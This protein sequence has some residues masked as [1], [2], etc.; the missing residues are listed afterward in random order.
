MR[1]TQIK[2][3][4]RFEDTRTGKRYNVKRGRNKTRSTD[5]YFYF[6]IGKRV[7]LSDKDFFTFFVNT[8]TLKMGSPDIKEGNILR[9]DGMKLLLPTMDDRRKMYK[10]KLKKPFSFQCYDQGWDDCLRM[11]KKLNSAGDE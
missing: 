7:Y 10:N 9:V 1:L 6:Y 4:G 8:E 11:I 3:V 2:S 5:H